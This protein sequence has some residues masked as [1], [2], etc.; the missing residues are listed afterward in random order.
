ML[1]NPKNYAIYPAVV[2]SD[3]ETVMTVV[4]T[5]RAFLLFE[6]EEYAV[7]VIAVDGDDSY[8]HIETHDTLTVTAR[9]G[10]L[11]FPYTFWGEQEFEL[12]LEYGDKKLANFHIYSLR[13]DLYALRPLRGDF[14]GH[15]YRSD[16]KQDPSALA[17][18]YREQG[19][20]F[21]SLT[22]HNRYYPGEEFD[23]TYA[24]VRLGIARVRGEEVHSPDSVVHIVHVGG[25]R[26]VTEQ[27]VHDREAYEKKIA[28]YMDKTP[29][30]LPEQYRTRYAKAMWATDAIHEAGGIAIF[31]HPYWKPGS[32][33]IHNVR[34]EFAKILL[35][36]GLF[37][38]YEL[39]GGMEQIGCNRSIALWGEMRARGVEIPVVGSSDVHGTYRAYS[40][41]HFFTI[42]FAEKNEN[43]SIVDAVRQGLCVAVESVGD[44]YDRQYRAYGSLRLVS[45]AQF[46]LTYYFPDLQRIC[47]G[48][49]VAMRTYAMGQASAVL[50]ELQVAQ[51]ENFTEQFF[52]R[53]AAVLPSESIRDFEA[54][55]REVHLTRGPHTKG[56]S[57][58][59]EKVNR[60]I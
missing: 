4:P 13:E 10:V 12:I 9:D 55:W 23:E 40:F 16:G 49:G 35:G 22:D 11:T 38:A 50:V 2:R 45:Y 27:Y 52:G 57:V 15:S 7:T 60:Q 14:H 19:Y 3:E 17:G 30:E 36:S 59:L 41:P 24:G 58:D 54:K 42:C 34:D 26:S 46:L 6:G 37:D 21:F 28:E 48:E 20:D 44:E 56:S 8:Y 43:D 25:K 33:R 39:I 5:E 32:S 47:Q 18:H 29:A 53:R 51:T 1:P 31:P